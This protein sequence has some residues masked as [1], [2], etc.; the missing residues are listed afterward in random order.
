[1]LSRFRLSERERRH[2]GG[3]SR[4]NDSKASS[5]ARRSTSSSPKIAERRS[6]AARVAPRSSVSRSGETPTLS[7]ATG[8]LLADRIVTVALDV[9]GQVGT[10]LLHDPPVHHDVHAVG[11]KILQNARIVR[12]DEQPRF[13]VGGPQRVHALADGA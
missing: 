13:R 12:D 5:R 3:G 9:V 2:G 6:T 1:M 7:D 8:D 4:W 11:L 10:A